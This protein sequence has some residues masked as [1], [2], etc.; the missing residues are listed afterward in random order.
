MEGTELI[1]FFKDGIIDSLRI[2]GMAQTLYH[3]FDDSVYQGKNKA[4]G[5]TIIMNFSH[6]ELNK[7]Q[8]LSGA[9][10]KYIPDSIAAEMDSP[11]IYSA[12]QIKYRLKDEESDFNGNANIEQDNTKLNAGFIKID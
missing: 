8:I 9:E 7:L 3:I 10:G 5:D 4:S 12:D 1:S 6:N 2:H 11:I